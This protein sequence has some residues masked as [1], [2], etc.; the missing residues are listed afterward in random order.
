VNGFFGRIEAGTTERYVSHGPTIMIRR[1]Y[2][3]NPPP[4]PP[5]T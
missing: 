4:K 1:M 3:P 2:M 5:Q